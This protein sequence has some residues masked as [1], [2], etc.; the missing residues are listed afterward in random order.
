MFKNVIKINVRNRMNILFTY[1][2]LADKNNNLGDNKIRKSNCLLLNFCTFVCPV[3]IYF[4]IFLWQMENEL[5]FYVK[6]YNC[7]YLLSKI[8]HLIKCIFLKYKVRRRSRKKCVKHSII[9]KIQFLRILSR[10]CV[11]KKMHSLFPNSYG[12]EISWIFITCL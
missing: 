1:I 10:F 12:L 4:K 7:F 2:L 3:N 5:K 11:K 9:V 8:Q 6:L